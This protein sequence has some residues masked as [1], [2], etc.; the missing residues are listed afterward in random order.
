MMVSTVLPVSMFSLRMST[1]SSRNLVSACSTWKNYVAED[2]QK[3]HDEIRVSP[4]FSLV[5]KRCEK[6]AN[7]GEAK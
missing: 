7:L 2:P 5:A 4:R 1:P 3:C 6:V